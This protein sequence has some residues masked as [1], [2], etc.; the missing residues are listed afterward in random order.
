M[1]VFRSLRLCMSTILVVVVILSGCNTG[2]TPAKVDSNQSATKEDNTLK[3]GSL[4]IYDML[5]WAVGNKEGLF[6]K[7]GVKVEMVPFRSAA[8]LNTALQA[9]Q[10][11]VGGEIITAILMNKDKEQVKIVRVATGTAPNAQPLFGIVAGKGTGLTKPADLKGKDIAVSRNTVIDYVTD[12]M[13]KKSGVDSKDVN[14]VTIP[15]IPVRLEMLQNG[16]LAAATL[17]EPLLTQAIKQGSA[18]IVDDSASKAGISATLVTVKTV[19]EKPN[20]LKKALAAYEQAVDKI[21]ANPEQYRALLVD[22]ASVPDAIKD[23]FA[24]PKF[25]KASVPSK[26]AIKD[27][28][29][30]MIE[31][32]MIKE[33]VPYEKLV[34]SSFLP[35]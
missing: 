25:P 14:K 20:T 13:L 27:I 2:S 26:E 28:N 19:K 3:V 11:D 1:K 16:Q 21:N 9:G 6:E 31:Q 8:E 18:L 15:Q 10:L 5:P 29:D 34:D 30:W 32:D 4:P 24:L 12:R 33:V 23:T 7:A 35:K 17:A 22:L